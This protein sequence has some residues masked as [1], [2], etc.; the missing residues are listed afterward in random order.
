MKKVLLSLS[1]ILLFVQTLQAQDLPKNHL[2]TNLFSYAFRG[3]NIAYER[4]LTKKSTVQLGFNYVLSGGIPFI[5]TNVNDGFKDAGIAN[6]NFSGFQLTPEYRFY[7]GKKGAG[8]GFYLAP[9]L[10]IANWSLKGDATL[11]DG[12]AVPANTIASVTLT[13]IGAGLAIGAQWVIK[14]RVSI[15]WTIFGLGFTSAKLKVAVTNENIAFTASEQAQ[16]RSQL[17]AQA[18][19]ATTE[20]TANS[21]SVS[22]GS[23]LPMFRTGLSIGVFF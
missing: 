23:L 18:V 6:L 7:T 1:S 21:A 11:T 5:G 12:T 10:R 2:K 19:G 14:N 17:Q 13:P 4:I 3:V 15:D 22:Y 20:V 16:L 9:F 8:K